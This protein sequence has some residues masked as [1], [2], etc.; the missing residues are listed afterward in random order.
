MN[1]SDIEISPF[2]MSKSWWRLKQEITLEKRDNQWVIT[3][4]KASMY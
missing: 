1:N 4:S 3:H 2:G